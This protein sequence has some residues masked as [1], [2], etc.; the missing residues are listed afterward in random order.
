M[1]KENN[2]ILIRFLP[3]YCPIWQ[4]YYQ[5]H[6]GEMGNIIIKQYAMQPILSLVSLLTVCYS[7][8]NC[9]T[10]FLFYEEYVLVHAVALTDC[11]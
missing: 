11:I 7:W 3:I 9:K 8:F 10:Y 1:I 2:Y 4:L 6:N 5:S